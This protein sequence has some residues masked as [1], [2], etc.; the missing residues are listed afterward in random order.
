M[1][2][3]DITIDTTVINNQKDTTYSSVTDLNEVNLF[4]ERIHTGAK[5]V[6]AQESE[7]YSSVGSMLF[8]CDVEREN[9]YAETETKMF[10]HTPSLVRK[11]Y[12][13]PHRMSILLLGTIIGL[14]CII[15][16]A[17]ILSYFKK[18]HRKEKENADKYYTY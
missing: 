5:I 13:P 8:V 1:D 16:I 11:E 6:N 9:L 15:I 17:V 4:T 14:V 7:K 3:A 12:V 2:N 10:I 18:K